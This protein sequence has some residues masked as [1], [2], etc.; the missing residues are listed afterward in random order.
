M[1]ISSHNTEEHIVNS[2]KQ[3]LHYGV[4]VSTP[5]GNFGMIVGRTRCGSWL[6]RLAILGLT[7]PWPESDLT[8]VAQS[9]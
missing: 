3:N 5:M 1:P 6:V 4:I 8:V 2:T 7:F 9:W